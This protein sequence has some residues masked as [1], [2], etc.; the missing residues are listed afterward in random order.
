MIEAA[1]GLKS[2]G[3]YFTTSMKHYVYIIQLEHA[4]DDGYC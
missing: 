1:H 4:K 3:L 2:I